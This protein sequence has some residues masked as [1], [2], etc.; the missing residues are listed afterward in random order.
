MGAEIAGKLKEV[1]D[2]LTTVRDIKAQTTG[3]LNRI[4]KAGVEMDGAGEISEAAKAMT[5]KLSEVEKKMTKGL[6]LRLH[7]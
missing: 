1:Y 5:E 7:R 2:G 3:I 4:E 6:P